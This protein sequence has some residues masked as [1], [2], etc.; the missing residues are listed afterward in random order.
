MSPL[1][2]A[3]APEL[4]PTYD[5]S[6]QS[7]HPSVVRFGRPWNGFLYWMA[8]TPYPNY[9]DGF[10]DPSIL[11]S[12]NGKRWAVP[13]GVENPLVPAPLVGH[14]CDVELVYVREE[15]ELRLYYV[16]ADDV[17]QS[18]V[19]LLRSKDGAHW[20]GPETVIHDPARK[21]GILSPAIQRL[22]DGTWQMWY[23]DTGD[24]GYICQE[25]AVRTRLSKDGIVWGEETTEA[26]SQP[27]HQIWHMTVWREPGTD[28]LHAVY[29][30]YPDR[31][32]CD[33]CRL[34]YAWKPAG[35]GWQTYGRPIMEPGPEGAWDDFC[36]YRTAFFLDRE[37]DTFRMWY[38]GKRRADAHWGIGYTEGSYSGMLR[39]LE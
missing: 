15:D 36:L 30:A 13:A 24:T 3:P 8:M 39:E 19:K 38:G 9:N 14:N 27:G 17:A 11:A 29:P 23:I 26:L 21:Y 20:T 37:R 7:T 28:T 22:G 4:I 10:E 32:N 35:Q 12:N 31:T 18:W 6:N 5:G 34:F 16:E 2:N 25:N 33:Y 1:K